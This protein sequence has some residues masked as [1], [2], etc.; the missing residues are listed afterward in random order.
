MFHSH[1]TAYHNFTYTDKNGKIAVRDNRLGTD[2]Y[3]N[4]YTKLKKGSFWYT[5]NYTTEPS[6]E[7]P[8]NYGVIVKDYS[9]KIGGIKW[10]GN[11]AVKHSCDGVYNAGCLT[12]DK[13]KTTFRKGDYI[14]ISFILL[15]WGNTDL[16]SVANMEKVYE[17]SGGP[18]GGTRGTPPS[19]RPK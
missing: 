19:G 18:Q 11:F 16:E 12:L 14:R 7:N 6:W 9:V 17:D 8:L 3:S 15:P 10:N 5:W 2:A 1:F 13:G 4:E